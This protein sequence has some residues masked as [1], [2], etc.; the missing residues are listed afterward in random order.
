MKSEITYPNIGDEETDFLNSKSATS[1]G[2]FFLYLP[3]TRL[4]RLHGLPEPQ[5]QWVAKQN[6]R[7]RHLI[8]QRYCSR[9]KNLDES[10]MGDLPAY[11]TAQTINRSISV[12]VPQWY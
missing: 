4:T 2:C 1:L 8:A 12:Y 7:I 3:M 11:L 9:E 10:L 5:S 6:V